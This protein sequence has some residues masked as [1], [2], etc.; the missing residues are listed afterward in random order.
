MDDVVGRSSVEERKSS[1][2]TAVST[3]RKRSKTACG[4]R[5]PV[6][7]RTPGL[8]RCLDKRVRVLRGKV[9]DPLSSPGS[10]AIRQT[11][12]L[13][14]NTEVF[15]D[16][17]TTIDLFSKAVANWVIDDSIYIDI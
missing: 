11:Y 4:N 7:L 9:R 15:I 10:Q 17:A 5:S 3:R 2:L 1:A 14:K 13:Q 12:R 6:F 16:L 8:A